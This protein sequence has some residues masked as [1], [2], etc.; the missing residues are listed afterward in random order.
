MLGLRGIYFKCPSRRVVTA[1]ANDAADDETGG[2]LQREGTQVLCRRGSAHLQVVPKSEKF[3][4]RKERVDCGHLLGSR[5]E[6]T[7]ERRFRQQLPADAA[8]VGSNGRHSPAGRNEIGGRMGLLLGGMLVCR[9]VGIDI[10]GK[11]GMYLVFALLCHVCKL[12]RKD[13]SAGGC[14]RLVATSRE[15]DVDALGERCRPQASR[16]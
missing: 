3:C 14:R 7:A 6:C 10:G 12:M 16:G 2:N 1:E 9:V 5:P 4:V 13:P 11:V 8:P 15:V